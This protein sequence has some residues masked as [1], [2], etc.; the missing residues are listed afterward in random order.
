M[1]RAKYMRF[2]KEAYPMS[3]GRGGNALERVIVV[4]DPRQIPTTPREAIMDE[5]L[6]G[7]A[8]VVLRAE[9]KD[10]RG[11]PVMAVRV[12]SLAAVVYFEPLQQL[13]EEDLAE[14]LEQPQR[15]RKQG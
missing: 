13:S 14:L 2:R 12:V 10:D 6:V 8:W 4:T 15:G 9:R 1:I 7:P 11:K 5:I 3:P